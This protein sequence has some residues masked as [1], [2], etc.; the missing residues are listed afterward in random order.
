MIG[1]GIDARVQIQQLIENQLPEFLLKAVL[2][3]TGTQ[4]WSN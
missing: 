2:Y 1:T 4:R 3:F